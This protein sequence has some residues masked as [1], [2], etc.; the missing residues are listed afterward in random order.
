LLLARLTGLFGLLALALAAVG[1]YGSLARLVNERVPELGV[2][3]VLGARRRDLLTMVLRHGLGLIALGLLVGLPISWML[4]RL[5]D[6]TIHGVARVDPTA[7]A[8]AAVVM[9]VS[10]GL[11]CALPALRAARIDPVD[12]LRRL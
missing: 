4:V 1:L 10:G 11:A 2:R 7:I 12:S 6:T 8:V 9:A 5:F 3:I